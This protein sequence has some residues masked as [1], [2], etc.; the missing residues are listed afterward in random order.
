MNGSFVEPDLALVNGLITSGVPTES[1]QEAVVIAG[2]RIV[3]TGSDE[4]LRPLI[5]PT[6]RV[7]DLKG[8]RVIPGLIDSHIHVVRAGLTWSERLDWSEVRSVSDALASIAEM[9]RRI[10]TGSWIMAVGGWHP[11]RFREGRGPTI[12]ELTRA[13]PDRAGLAALGIGHELRAGDFGYAP[14]A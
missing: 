6:T 10:P 5:G 7:F 1:D 13:A 12:A 9:A 8:S 4:E 14:L 2:G 11:G 3:A